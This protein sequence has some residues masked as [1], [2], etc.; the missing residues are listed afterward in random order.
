[1]SGI[2]SGTNIQM[3]AETVYNVWC[4]NN[5]EK[6]FSCCTDNTWCS[7]ELF[8]GWTCVRWVHTNNI[9]TML[10]SVY[11]PVHELSV[12]IIN[13]CANWLN[14]HSHLFSQAPHQKWCNIPPA[15]A[16]SKTCRDAGITLG[17]YYWQRRRDS[18]FKSIFVPMWL[19]FSV[20]FMLC[21][22]YTRL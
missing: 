20:L 19:M 4:M 16:L 10:G 21:F 5:S 12:P 9:R 8:R 15:N 7:V 22:I 6:Y 18:R 14:S 13:H 1:M 2:T 3:T 11:S 17:Q